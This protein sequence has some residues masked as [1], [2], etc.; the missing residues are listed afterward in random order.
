MQWLHLVEQCGHVWV[1]NDCPDDIDGLVVYSLS[2]P[3]H[4]ISKLGIVHFFQNNIVAQTCGHS[5]PVN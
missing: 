2:Q 1:T 5:G 4:E 3:R